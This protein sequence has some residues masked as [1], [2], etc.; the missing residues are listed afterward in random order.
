MRTPLFILC[1]LAAGSLSAQ[2]A[3]AEP[4]LDALSRAD[5]NYA[6]RAK[7]AQGAKANPAAIDAA[8]A[9]YRDALKRSP[10][11][12]PL[13]WRLQRAIFFRAVYCGETQE[14]RKKILGDARAI[15]DEAVA[16]L[17]TPLKGKP[18]A[19]RLAALRA[20]PEA[21]SLYLWDAAVWGEWALAY[22]KMAAARQGAAAKI[23]DLSQTVIDLDPALEDGGGYR[24]LG[25]L[26]HQSP[27]IPFIT[28]WVDHKLAAPLLRK[29]LAAGPANRVNQFFLAE[30][31]LDG[32]AAA[33]LEAG[34]V[35]HG[36]ADTAPRAEF[37]V[38]DAEY[39]ARCRARLAGK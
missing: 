17:E 33:V 2:S 1:L 3:P 4:A 28:G 32:D 39:A 6:N 5:A 9:G 26:H 24:V 18:A 29:A 19:A 35:L 7:D 30:A 12:I 36:C 22:G 31:L 15:G 16:T 11:S 14:G 27:S 13:R 38:E 8:I 20:A 10:E 25:R 34:K 23:R 21:A 37:L